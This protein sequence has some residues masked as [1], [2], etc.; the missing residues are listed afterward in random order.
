MG[1][2][3]QIYFNIYKADS[4]NAVIYQVCY[5]CYRIEIHSL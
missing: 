2:N 4:Q 3:N 5:I 1:F